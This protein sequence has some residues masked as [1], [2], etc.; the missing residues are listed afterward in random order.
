MS[1]DAYVEARR[2]G[3]RGLK[4]L[5]ISTNHQIEIDGDRARCRSAYRIHRVDPA[6]AP[7]EDR[8]DA[9]G[10][11]EHDLVQSTL[12]MAHLRHQANRGLSRG[13]LRSSWRFSVI[14]TS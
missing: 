14:V 11:Y 9:A 1:A 3:L 6:R 4:T 13:H 12:W 5:H 2:N 8:L 10:H 7:G